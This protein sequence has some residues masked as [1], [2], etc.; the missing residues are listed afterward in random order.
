MSTTPAAASGTYSGR[1]YV[2]GSG[3][4]VDDWNDEGLLQTNMHASSNATCLWQK[5]LWADGF[6]PSTADIDG[7]FGT[8]T[9]NAT[10]AWQDSVSLQKDGS[11]GKA[12]FG[13]AGNYLHYVASSTGPNNSLDLYY[14]GFAHN[15]P[16]IRAVD[17]NYLFPEG[18]G[19][20]YKF[21]SYNS[22]S[23]S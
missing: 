3:T 23:C 5:I 13:M 7:V 21:A 8:K 4:W 20:V 9:Y 14:D 11:V 18:D 15:F 19:G 2:Y 10:V 22:R 16:L 17:G 12:T 6:L 1:A